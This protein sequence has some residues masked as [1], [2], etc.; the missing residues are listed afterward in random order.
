MT[1]HL[2]EPIPGESPCGP[3]M[4]Y[5]VAFAEL[6]RAVMGRPE[7]QV[8]DSIVPAEPPN[9]RDVASQAVELLGATK[10]LR[11]AVHL[12][13]AWLNIDG[14]S[15]L[16]NGLDL[17]RELLERYWPQLHPELDPDDDNDPTM[18]LNIL[19]GLCEPQTVLATVR[20]TSLVSVR[21]L[22][23]YSL[24]DVATA[25]EPAEDGDAVDMAT[26]NA[27]FTAADPEALEQMATDLARA[28]EHLTAIETFV[29]SQ[30]GPGLGPDLGALR[31]LLQR[32]AKVLDEKRPAAAE[33]LPEEEGDDDPIAGNAPAQRGPACPRGPIVSREEVVETLDAIC[34][35]YQQYE[36]S[37]P[38]PLLLRRAK[39]LV[40]KGFLE[41]LEDLA[42][43]GVNQVKVIQ[44]PQDTE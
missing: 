36:P 7:Q 4:E 24:R 8:G 10:D 13:H 31:V 30:V 15:G 32:G 11:P 20:V 33:V 3:N 35:Y 19:A 41:I 21:G 42:P 6:E 16:A 1:A 40:H 43:D 2:L 12:T 5:E 28:C 25:A 37:S 39:S 38:L 22:G 9:W 27:A 34:S 29:A 44:G 26:I 17:L 14:F 23:S 18:R